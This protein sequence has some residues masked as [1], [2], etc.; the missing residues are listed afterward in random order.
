MEINEVLVALENLKTE[1]ENVKRAKEEVEKAVGAAKTLSDGFGAC[2]KN[3]KTAGDSMCEL[4]KKVIAVQDQFKAAVVQPLEQ[5][6]AE[7][8]RAGDA[9]RDVTGEI[10]KS[11]SQKCDKATA[12][13]GETVKAAVRDINIRIGEFHEE[14]DSFSGIVTRMS[15]RV[16]NA[17]GDVRQKVSSHEKFVREELPELFRKESAGTIKYVGDVQ[18]A[19]EQRLE[20]ECASVRESIEKKLDAS[21]AK[22]QSGF[23]KVDAKIELLGSGIKKLTV[24]AG[25]SLIAGIGSLAVVSYLVFKLVLSK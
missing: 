3:F 14:L 2:G 22:T 20:N 9:L 21:E 18:D 1:L 16:E 6:V 12:G 7:I 4:I 5:K 25:C 17:I 10:A 13:L 23:K 11:F 15:S 24:I 8:A 19:V